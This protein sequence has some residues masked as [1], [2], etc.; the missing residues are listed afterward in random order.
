MPE[1][2]TLLEAQVAAGVRA[3]AP[4]G[5][6]GRCKKCG[7]EVRR[8]GQAAWTQVLACQTRV[9]CNLEVRTPEVANAQ[10]LTEGSHEK[11][12]AAPMVRAIQVQVLPCPRGDHI[13][14]WQRVKLALNMPGLTADPHTL[15]N[16]GTLLRKRQGKLWVVIG[17]NVLLELQTD[18]PRIYMAAF[19]IGTTTLAGYLLD[20][21]GAPVATAAM[22]N[23]Q[24]CFGADVITRASYAL[25]NGTEKLTQA[26]Q[27]GLNALLGQLCEAAQ[28]ERGQ[29]Y[30]I[31]AAGNSC[32]HHLF[33]G[34]SPCSLVLSPYTTTLR[35]PLVLNAVSC[36]LDAHPRA[37]LWILPLIAGFVGADTVGCLV[38]GGWQRRQ[39]CTLLI[40]IGTNGELVLGN[41]G[42]RI[43]CSTAA[44][45]ALEGA[46]IECGMRG[47]DGA[48]DH[49][50]WESGEVCWHVIGDR[51]PTGIC[52]SG[53][54]DLLAVLLKN[55]EMDESGRLQSGN[56]FFLGDTGVYLTQKDIREVQLAKAAISAGIVLL[57]KKLGIGLSNIAEV[58]IAGAFGSFMNPESAC[59]IGLIP[60]EL[61]GK[62]RIIGNAAGEGA[63]RVLQDSNAW[64]TARL[65]AETTDFLELATLP[66]FQDVFV[67]ALEFPEVNT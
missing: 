21:S 55:G 56:R 38:S 8:P 23:P 54:V 67:D 11:L 62:I 27:S 34:I 36:G 30:A 26:V 3:D 4:C 65:L 45:P 66:E 63:K 31:S 16:L 60:G 37:Q 12:R 43:A 52:G 7:V 2:V 46:K 13:S 1:D 41:A 39:A 14:D 42:G 61:L 9:R 17:G 49:V 40:D 50:W 15:C 20:C 35:E 19:D 59:A 18:E 29:V 24:V 48:I 53:I 6:R 44:G 33:L 25:E 47:S 64:D 58:H 32:M 28:V 51:A 57:A 10:I 5:G 22:L